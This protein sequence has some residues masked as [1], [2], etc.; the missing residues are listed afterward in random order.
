VLLANMLEQGLSFEFSSGES[1]HPI[2]VKREPKELQ[3][4]DDALHWTMTMRLSE[5]LEKRLEEA[6]RTRGVSAETILEQAIESFLA[7]A[8]R[9]N[10][11]GFVIPSFAGSVASSDPNWIDEHERLLWNDNHGD[12]GTDR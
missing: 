1:E 8:P 10:A 2:R 3:N 5:N 7:E 4:R 6:A 11:K 9:R 12:H